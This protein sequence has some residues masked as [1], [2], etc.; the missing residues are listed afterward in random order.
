MTTS[1]K[2]RNTPSLQALIQQPIVFI[3]FGFGSG[4]APKAPGTWGTLVGVLLF[5]LLQPLPQ[6]FYLLV[7]VMVSIV[8]IWICGHA[9][10]VLGVHD[11]SGIVWDEI[12]GYL[13]TMAFLPSEWIWMAAGFAAFRLFDILKPWP[14]C[15]LDRRLGGGLGIM[16]DDVVAGLLAGGGLWLLFIG[17]LD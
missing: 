17:S 9:A 8:G 3:A 7:V 1:D 11:H 6:M 4:L 15:V 13:I 2:H 12:A 14:I 16:L 5:L 10:T